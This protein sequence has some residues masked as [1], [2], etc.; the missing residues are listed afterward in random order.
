MKSHTPTLSVKLSISAM[1]S[2]LLAQ[3]FVPSFANCS[4]IKQAIV[5]NADPSNWAHFNPRLY[6]SQKRLV[7]SPSSVPKSASSYKKGSPMFPHDPTKQSV[8]FGQG[9]CSWATEIYAKA[10]DFLA[11]PQGYVQVPAAGESREVTV[12]G[13]RLTIYGTSCYTPLKESASANPVSV[14]PFDPTRIFYKPNEIWPAVIYG[15][16]GSEVSIANQK[17]HF[18]GA[19]EKLIVT[20]DAN[21]RVVAASSASNT[22]GPKS[23]EKAAEK[24]ANAENATAKKAAAEKAPAAEKAAAEQAALEKVVAEQTAAEKAATE[25]A[26]AEKAVGG[27]AAATEKAAVE[28]AT[29]AKAAT[30]NAASEKAAAEQ[31]ATE[32]GATEKPATENLAAADKVATEKASAD[33]SN[34]SYIMEEDNFDY[35]KYDSRVA[36]FFYL[37]RRPYPSPEAAFAGVI[38]AHKLIFFPPGVEPGP[39]PDWDFAGRIH[40]YN[41]AWRT[42]TWSGEGTTLE[43]LLA[44]L[45][46]ESVDPEPTNR[47]YCYSIKRGLLKRAGD[48]A[49]MLLSNESR[50]RDLVESF[51]NLTMSPAEASDGK[52]SQD[53]VK[54]MQKSIEKAVQDFQRELQNLRE[55]IQHSLDPINP[56]NQFNKLF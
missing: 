12:A 56:A 8:V 2:I 3:T 23:A 55:K 30:E 15:E 27:N 17:L 44:E 36:K 52:K 34:D 39:L 49:I 4:V 14:K 40:F 26:V 20:F 18:P 47:F 43:S 45:R 46:V 1:L 21:G 29:A 19:G 33:A 9:Q 42:T 38:A 11:F 24:G 28:N 51:L 7:P 13:Q 32:K 54:E 31:V 6:R 10:Y 50:E 37:I 48:N 25:Q 41:G 53:P 35:S 22:P 16:P 5:Q